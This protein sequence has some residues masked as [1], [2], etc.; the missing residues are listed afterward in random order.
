V[1]VLAYEFSFQHNVPRS[2]PPVIEARSYRIFSLQN[3]CL[4]LAAG[5]LDSPFTWYRA[6]FKR[7]DKARPA[8][9][10]TLFATH[11]VVDSS[12]AFK[13][14]RFVIAPT[15]LRQNPLLILL[16]AIK[17]PLPNIMLLEWEV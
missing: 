16:I 15:S 12:S 5:S 3:P 7:S 14:Y 1:K 9:K 10:Q 2:L 13:H 8:C 17:T 6:P 4:T 11:T